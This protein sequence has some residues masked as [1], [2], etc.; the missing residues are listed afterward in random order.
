MLASATCWTACSSTASTVPV[1]FAP[2]SNDSTSLPSS[3]AG[4]TVY[5]A[6]PR[7]AVSG[8]TVVPS[9]ASDGSASFSA[10]LD[11]S[12]ASI[13][14]VAAVMSALTTRGNSSRFPPLVGPGF[15]TSSVTGSSPRGITVIVFGSTLP[16]GPAFTAS[17]LTAALAGKICKPT[18]SARG[19]VTPCVVR[20]RD[21]SIRVGDDAK[22]DRPDGGLLRGDHGRRGRQEDVRADS[23][24]VESQGQHREADR[25]RGP[26]DRGTEPLGGARRGANARTGGRHYIRGRVS[27]HACRRYRCRHP[28]RHLRLGLANGRRGGSEISRHRA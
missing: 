8:N 6:S 14:F 18:S 20:Y 22:I 3:V 17:T 23:A 1:A 7:L 24:V 4:S 26:R 10:K 12:W 11:A 28:M 19:T 9:V 25:D 21:G 5:V 27:D 16:S 13:A 2:R 15:V